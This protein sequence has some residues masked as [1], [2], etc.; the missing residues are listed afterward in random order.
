MSKFIGAILFATSLL[1]AQ[2]PGN[3]PTRTPPTPAEIAQ[4][5]VDGLTRFLSLR[6]DQQAAALKI[7]TDQATADAGLQSSLKT[8]RDSLKAAV[9]TNDAGT[10]ANVST[11][12]GNLTGQLTASDA[13]AN[14]AFYQLL[15]A[16]Q[17]SKFDQ[18]R[19]GMGGFGR[20][21]GGPGGPGGFR[22]RRQ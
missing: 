14:A 4:R 2:G 1:S 16:D 5:R 20:G 3:Q 22:G 18:V 10:I 7:F 13:K 8:E 17:K 6:T 19:G 12:I 9:K 21:P 15:D 11:Q